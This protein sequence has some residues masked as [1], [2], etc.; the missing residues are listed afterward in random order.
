MSS[1]NLVAV[2][3]EIA[4]TCNAVCPVCIRRNHGQLAEFTQ[5]YRTAEEVKRILSDTTV[6][7]YTILR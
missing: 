6:R 2:D 4:S 5:Q 7:A 1:G 3:F